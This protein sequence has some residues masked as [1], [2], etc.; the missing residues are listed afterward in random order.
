[1]NQN[2]CGLGGNQGN[3]MYL[4]EQQVNI[5]FNLSVSSNGMPNNG[6]YGSGQTPASTPFNNQQMTY[7]FYSMGN[8]CETLWGFTL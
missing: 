3:G 4:Q 8:L 6:A 2:G 7:G 5:S 1:M